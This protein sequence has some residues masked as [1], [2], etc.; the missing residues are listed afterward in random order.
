MEWDELNHALDVTW[1]DIE[2]SYTH[3]NAKP[4]ATQEAIEWQINFNLKTL[5]DS[6]SQSLIYFYP[7]KKELIQE[8]IDDQTGDFTWRDLNS[9]AKHD[10]PLYEGT[11]A[12][13]KIFFVL[14][15]YRYYLNMT[16]SN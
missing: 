11:S 2:V 16:D 15:H 14:D 6:I 12:I 5:V 13:I 4:Q 1:D 7:E 8:A 3:R 9:M 10:D